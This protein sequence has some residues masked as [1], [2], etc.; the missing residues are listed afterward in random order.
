MAVLMIVAVAATAATTYAITRSGN[1]HAAQPPQPSV[2][3]APNT[4]QFT[5]AD[6]AAATTKLC[7]VFDA[8]ARGQ[9]GQGGVIVNG[10]VNLPVVLRTVNSVVAVQN[11]LTPAV[12]DTV[13]QTAR[14]YIDSS[15]NLTAAA[16]GNASVDDVNRLTS[17]S[18][19]ATYAL[20]DACGLR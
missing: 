4:P 1:Q 10:E 2:T 16:T 11:A 13:A 3:A 8:T 6:Q 19:D 14:T 12:P 7:G 5:S 15:L 20:V 9:K 18:N 17:A